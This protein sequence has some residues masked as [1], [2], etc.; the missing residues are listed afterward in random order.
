MAHEAPLA[1]LVNRPSRSTLPAWQA[2]DCAVRAVNQW[3]GQLK[4]KPIESAQRDQPRGDCR[5]AHADKGLLAVPFLIAD[6]IRDKGC[7]W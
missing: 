2:A 1:R 4:V 7:R 3:I 6:T 5:N